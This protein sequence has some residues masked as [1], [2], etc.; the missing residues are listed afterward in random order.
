MN[1]N[2]N[3]LNQLIQM[4]KTSG[5]ESLKDESE[6]NDE[7]QN[8]TEKPVP[9]ELLDELEHDSDSTDD[10]ENEKNNELNEANERLKREL[11]NLQNENNTIK[12]DLENER[13]KNRNLQNQ[14]YEIESVN[15]KMQIAPTNTEKNNEKPKKKSVAGIKDFIAKKKTIIIVIVVVLV[16]AIIFAIL[17]FKTN[18]FK[19]KKAEKADTG[20]PVIEE[21]GE[22]KEENNLDDFLK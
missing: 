13:E 20:D 21:P 9:K 5:N 1:D 19:G 6:I 3:D 12:N 14:L 10:L 11:N 4:A 16:V 8:N 18:L 15:S 22:K 7:N 2:E 17:Y